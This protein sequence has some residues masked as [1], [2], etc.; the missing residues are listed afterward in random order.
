VEVVVGEVLHQ[1]GEEGEEPLRLMMV[2]VEEV[3]ALL[4]RVVEVDLVGE[5]VGLLPQL[6]E[7]EVQNYC[8]Q[9][10]HSLD[11]FVFQSC[12]FCILL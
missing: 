5:G 11:M 9:S 1:V 3:E 8:S 2:E 4:L 10:L 7:E 6:K 12:V